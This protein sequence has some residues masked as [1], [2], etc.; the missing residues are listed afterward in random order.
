MGYKLFRRGSRHCSVHMRPFVRSRTDIARIYH[1]KVVNVVKNANNHP[2]KKVLRKNPSIYE[3]SS[4]PLDLQE[5]SNRI[6]KKP[7]VL[8]PAGGWNQLIAAAENGADA[9]YFG[10]TRFNARARAENF[11]LEELPNVMSYLHERGMKGYL[12]LN[13]LVF[14]DEVLSMVE[15]AQHARLA[16]VDAVIVQDL[17]VV[18]L[19]KAAAP[20]LAIHG[21]TQMTVTSLEGLEYAASLGI[22]RIVVGRE[23]SVSDI[24]EVSRGNAEVEAFVHGALCVSYSGQC[25][26]SE[27]WGGRSANRGQCAQACRLPYGLIVDGELKDF[28]EQYVLSPQDLAAVDLMPELIQAGVVSLKIEGRLKGPEYV[29]MTT[30]V[31]RNAV[32][33]AWNAIQS[34]RDVHRDDLCSP[35]MWDDMRV[36]FAR[37]QDAEHGGLTHG[38]L[39]GSQHQTLVRGR[40]PRHRGIFLGEVENVDRKAIKIR[41]CADLKLGDGLVIDQ[42][43]PESEELGGSVFELYNNNGKKVTSATK[44]SIV[45]VGI[46]Q[47]PIDASK[48]SV[49]DLIWKNKDPA[50]M[51][52]L[53]ASYTSVAALSRRRIPLKVHIVCTIGERLQVHI[54]DFQGNKAMAMTDSCVQIA[55]K[56]PV[57]EQDFAKAVGVHLGDEG[58]FVM[59]E[60]KVTFGEGESFISMK[61]V[62]N[63]RRQALERFMCLSNEDIPIEF[64]NPATVVES[65][66]ERIASQKSSCN[67]HDGP[68]VRILCRTPDQVAAAIEVEW[69]EEII[70]DFLEVKGLAASCEKVRAAGK[71]VIVATPRIMKPDEKHLWV[72]YVKLSADALLVRGT[73]MIHHFMKLGGPGTTIQEADNAPIPPLQGDFSL[74][75]TNIVTADLL[76][77]SGLESLALTYDCNSDQICGILQ[78]LGERSNQVEII[79]HTNLPIFHTEHCLFARFL[80]NGNSYLDCGRP[81]EKHTLHIR[82]PATSRDHLIEADMGCRNTVFEGSSQTAIEYM[83]AFSQYNVGVYRIELVDQPASIVADILEGYKSVLQPNN[84]S[85]SEFTDWMQTIP[86]ANGRCHGTTSGSFQ[87]THE[88]SKKHMKKTA[89]SLRSDSR[90]L[91]K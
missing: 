6:L 58:S 40:S 46:G 82:D 85:P 30:R 7:E 42:G 49:G 38:F 37:A 81:C 33:T 9:V 91:R 62:K 27:A 31:Y 3:S 41:L 47:I 75:A 14:D 68:R 87:V 54:E 20:G 76:L 19:I 15:T 35:Q 8:A 44:G 55:S 4:E 73:G 16:Q 39:S 64:P 79:C 48:V 65:F 10:V 52:S 71:R 5:P 90:I 36:T 24:A 89:A 60:C 57:T 61:D 23:L 34:G 80:S 13:V 78:G 26:S 74:N 22:D 12:V 17:G 50:L 70:L 63:A 45:H 21:S 28:A 86:D 29:A 83:N 32:D 59:H 18:E 53:K 88:Q 67:R 72:Y 56:K 77:N 2:P 25:F 66:R 69:L 51:S 11:T 43:T 84:L 1:F